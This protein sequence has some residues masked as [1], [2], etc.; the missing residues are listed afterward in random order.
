MKSLPPAVGKAP[1]RAVAWR[2][3]PSRDARSSSDPK[4][5]GHEYSAGPTEC[6]RR[7]RRTSRRRE[8][9]SLGPL[10][11]GGA[12]LD[13]QRFELVE[14]RFIKSFGHAEQRCRGAR[15][16]AVK[17]HP[18]QFLE[19]GLASLTVGH[20]RPEEIALRAVCATN[21]TF[22]L[23]AAEHRANGRP[24][25]SSKKNF[26]NLRRGKLASLVEQVDDLTFPRW[27][28]LQHRPLHVAPHLW[29]ATNVARPQQDLVNGV[30]SPM[31]V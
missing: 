27:Q 9:S 21:E 26:R 29:R 6:R 13:D 10:A 16:G 5:S 4:P 31:T 7:S 1:F 18:H 2:S 12:G 14:L 23:E 28:F 11:S 30:D 19:R 25:A 3:P 24:A 17:E 8:R 22:V 20:S 15:G